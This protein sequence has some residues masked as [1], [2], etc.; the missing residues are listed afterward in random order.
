MKQSLKQIV[1]Q[2]IESVQLSREQL[3]E[4]D[5]LQSSAPKHKKLSR[6]WYSMAGL[7]AMIMLLVLSQQDSFIGDNNL[8][9]NEL[10]MEA[11]KNHRYQ[12]PLEVNAKQLTTLRHYFTELDFSPINSEFLQS[13]NLSLM[14]GRYC[15]LQG[16]T[17]AQLRFKSVS[18]DGVK[19]LY[20]VDYDPKIFK[21]LPNFDKG[22]QPVTTYSNGIKV[23][24]WVEK[25]VLF[26]LTED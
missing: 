19:T 2:Q 13:K 8:L 6:W 9:I 3:D 23:T 1:D 22:E 12:K 26:A 20:Q 7:A 25:G 15:S 10:A 21:S 4:L 14:G 5:L 16:V 11:A 18:A 17:A 24:L